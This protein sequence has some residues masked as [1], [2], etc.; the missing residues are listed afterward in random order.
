[1]PGRKNILKKLD[2]DILQIEEVNFLP[3][4]FDGNRMFVFPPV[5]VPYSHTK[6]KSMDGMDKRYNGHVWTK[7]QT[8]NIT[9]DLG[10]VFCVAT[11]SATILIATTSNVF[12]V[13]PQLMIL[14]SMD[15]PRIFF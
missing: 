11:S 2:Y 12:I 1:M 5:G 3:P 7:T 10:L 13:L 6:A 8:T 15:L 9:N 14:H 4:R